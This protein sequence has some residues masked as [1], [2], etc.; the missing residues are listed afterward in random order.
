MP[1]LSTLLSRNP[2]P[3]RPP[4]ACAFRNKRARAHG[5]ENALMPQGQTLS[6]HSC[7]CEEVASSS[8]SGNRAAHGREQDVRLVS[9]VNFAAWREI[10]RLIPDPNSRSCYSH[11][12]RPL[13]AK[14]NKPVILIKSA[15]LN[16]GNQR[17]IWVPVF[18]LTSSLCL[19]WTRPRGSR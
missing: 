1:T 18:K 13:T 3:R 4:W 8:H 15:F 10:A 9:A 5:S 16:P 14:E 17:G 7:L 19:G 6:S 12:K 11:H 2:T